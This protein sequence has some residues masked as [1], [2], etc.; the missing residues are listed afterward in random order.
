MANAIGGIKMKKKNTAIR[1]AAQLVTI[2]IT[3]TI[4]IQGAQY[5]TSVLKFM[6]LRDSM[7]YTEECAYDYK[8]TDNLHD[9]YE[10]AR[11]EIIK[12]ADPIVRMCYTNNTRMKVTTFVIGLA[13]I[14]SAFVLI[15]IIKWDIEDLKN[16]IK[17]SLRRHARCRARRR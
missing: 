7:E 3:V 14:F 5:M 11:N 8:W 17:K 4:L 9:Q 16:K 12:N 10:S 2:I 6:G 13:M 15:T 1:L